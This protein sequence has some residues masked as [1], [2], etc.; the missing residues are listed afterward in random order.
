MEVISNLYFY[1][2]IIFHLFYKSSGI[3]VTYHGK[4]FPCHCLNNICEDYTDVHYTENAVCPNG[5]Q[6]GWD[7]PGCQRGNVAQGKDTRINDYPFTL[8]GTNA[9]SNCVDGNTSRREEDNTCCSVDSSIDTQRALHVVLGSRH[10][11]DSVIL[12]NDERRTNDF[13]DM[14]IGFYE[15]SATRLFV[16]ISS[17]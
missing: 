5:C 2:I 17:T 11:I 10:I 13:T 3:N 7:G 9:S 6:A 15:G 16:W 12:Y 4:D 1:Y 14:Y 8:H